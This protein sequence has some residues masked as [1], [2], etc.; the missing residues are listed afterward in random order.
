MSKVSAKTPEFTWVKLAL[1]LFVGAIFLAQAS[2]VRAENAPDAEAFI[3]T[4]AEEAIGLLNDQSKTQKQRTDEFADLVIANADMTAIGYFTL[5]QYRR[6]ATPDQLDTFMDLFQGYTKNFY[7]LRLSEYA[8]QT[9]E[10][11]GSQL[12]NNGKEVIVTSQLIQP[13]GAPT[14]VN[15]R[16]RKNA[17]G[18]YKL[19]D[20]QVVGVW[21]ALEQRSQ[22][23]ATIANNNGSFDSLLD[24]LRER[25]ASGEGFDTSAASDTAQ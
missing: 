11:T 18:E 14:D 7:S 13:E 21:L 1:A 16:L 2:L 25:V 12:V 3:N 6:S 9:L 24:V 15:W 4:V 10:V 23:T 17:E 5:G 19:R 22:F 8:N 20:L